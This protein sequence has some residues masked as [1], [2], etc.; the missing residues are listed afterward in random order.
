MSPDVRIEAEEIQYVLIQDVIKR[1]VLE[2]D[3]ALDAGRKPAR[4][5]NRAL[6]TKSEKGED[7]AAGEDLDTQV[8]ASSKDS[9]EQ[10]GS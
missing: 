5:A 1:E 6:R 9:S 7:N 2:G 10:Q 3:K 4:A 8:S